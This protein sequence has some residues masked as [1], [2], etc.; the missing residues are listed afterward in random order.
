MIS[1]CDSDRSEST[2]STAR[3]ANVVSASLL[4]SKADRMEGEP[5]RHLEGLDDDPIRVHAKTKLTRYSA[6]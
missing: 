6:W 2:R 5:M 1:R 4:R 3:N